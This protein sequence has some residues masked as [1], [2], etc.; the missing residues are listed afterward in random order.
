MKLSIPIPFAASFRLGSTFIV[1][2][3]VC[4]QSPGGSP[5]L[6]K[7]KGLNG[8]VGTD[9]NVS[10]SFCL[11]CLA[12]SLDKVLSSYVCKALDIQYKDELV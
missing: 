3:N 5:I 11:F 10:S 4:N 12:T 6:M 2:S 1:L 8:F 7:R 9:V